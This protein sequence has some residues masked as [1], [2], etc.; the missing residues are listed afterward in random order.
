M[1]LFVQLILLVAATT[2]VADPVRLRTDSLSAPI[3]IDTTRPAFSWQSDSRTMNWKQTGYQVLVATD[4]KL[5]RPGAADAWDSGRVASGESLQIRYAGAPLKSQQRYVW[6][7]RVWDDKGQASPWARSSF[8]M[9]LL[10]ASDWKAAW[11]MRKD[12]AAA[13]EIASVRWI[14]VP[15]VDTKNVTAGTPAHFLYRLHLDDKS[16]AASLHMLAT[17]Q[18][19]ARVNGQVTG[20]HENWGA[21]DREEITG[22]LHTGDNDIEL[23]CVSRKGNAP[24]TTSYA[25]VA[26]SIHITSADGRERRIVSDSTWMARSTSEDTWKP[27]QA[28][29]PMSANYSAGIDGKPAPGPDR[30]STDASLFR[31]DFVS[32]GTVTSARLS[33]TALGAYTAYINGHAVAPDTLLAPGWTDFRKRA[34]FQTYDVTALLSKGSNTLA[35]MLGGGWYSSPM[36]W[37]GVRVTPGPNL[38]R[39]QLDLTFADGTH[40]TIVT[41]DSWM[42]APSAITFSE[43]YGGESFD[44]RLQ[45]KGWT[46]VGF[47]AGGWTRAAAGSP[48][49]AAITLTAQPDLPI[50]NTLV[51]KPSS[52][53]V[54]NSAHPAVFDMGQ[55]MVAL[56]H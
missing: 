14:W 40:R 22:L 49:N 19:I 37:A 29:G 30:V 36:T 27:A 34:Q 50:S 5:L 4:E 42:T 13:A 56:L 23:D 54:A 17:G 39:A 41:D 47:A 2:A 52:V 32:T 33:V 31:K 7:V 35:A 51:L 21:F 25:A 12:P 28:V 15:G 6:A 45:Q 20:K 8:E 44:A 18:V 48:P 24:A 26:A 16:Q 46:Q 10:S 3:G 55:N 1:R 38:L 53:A 9:G 43:I 11:I